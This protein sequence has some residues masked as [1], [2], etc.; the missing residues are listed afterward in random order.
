MLMIAVIAGAVLLSVLVYALSG[1]RMFLF[2]LPLVIAL[3][4]PGRR[5]R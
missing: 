3:P 1:G 2:L 4:L 5:R